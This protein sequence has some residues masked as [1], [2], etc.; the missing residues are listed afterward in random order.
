M[1]MIMINSIY[2]QHIFQHEIYDIMENI[3]YN[4][5]TIVILKGKKES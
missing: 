3:G 5:E 1:L 4:F 2:S